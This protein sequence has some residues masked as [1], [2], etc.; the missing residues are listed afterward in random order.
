MLKNL[1]TEDNPNNYQIEYGQEQSDNREV[2]T[3]MAGEVDEL[4]TSLHE[5]IITHH[6][7][8]II[9]NNAGGKFF[10]FYL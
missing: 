8:K 9:N 4:M 2:G 3:L 10:H 1:S 6:L 7:G 5:K